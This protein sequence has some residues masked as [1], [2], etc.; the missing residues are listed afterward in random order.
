MTNICDNQRCLILPFIANT[1]AEEGKDPFGEQ[2]PGEGVDVRLV[3]HVKE[4]HS[5]LL[6]IHEDSDEL[7]LLLEGETDR[8]GVQRPILVPAPQPYRPVAVLWL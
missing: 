8:G 1:R 3:L 4:R 7:R 2:T 5:P 6:V